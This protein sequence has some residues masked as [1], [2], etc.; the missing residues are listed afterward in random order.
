MVDFFNQVDEEVRSERMR[1]MARKYLPWVAGL[2]V[3]ALVIAGGFWAYDAWRADAASK[4]SVAYDR[5]MKAIER[6]DSAAADTA[7]AEAAGMASPAYKSLAL[8]Q[9]GGIAL[10]DNKVDEAVK[11]FDEAAKAAP[12]PIMADA[13]ALKAIFALMDTAPYAS[14]EERLKPLTEEGRPYRPI[15]REALAMAKLQAGQAQAA[16]GEFVALSL[17][18]DAPEAMRGRAQAAIQMIDSGAAAKLPAIAKAAAALPPRAPA[19]ASPFA[20]QAGAPAPQAGA[21]PQ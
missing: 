11:F 19:A 6:D 12:S 3:A 17:S 21:A 13:A 16:R 18:L 1:D 4:A 20:S 14:I 10:R 8:M 2:L 15:A 9:R 7:F 5:G